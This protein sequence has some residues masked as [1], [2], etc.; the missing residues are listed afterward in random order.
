[1]GSPRV[2][3]LDQAVG[4]CFAGAP[5]RARAEFES[6]TFV[7]VDAHEGCE[8][9]RTEQR[10]GGDMAR[11]GDQRGHQLSI[12]RGADCRQRGNLGLVQRQPQAEPAP[13]VLRGY[14]Y[15]ASDIVVGLGKRRVENVS[16]D[17]YAPR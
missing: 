11:D 3:V 1:M 17:G 14:L 4:E 6:L 10:R 5:E 12:D 16:V 15:V 13:D 9:T 8:A 7:A 2:H